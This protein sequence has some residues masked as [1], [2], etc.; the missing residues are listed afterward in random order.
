MVNR[1]YAPIDQDVTLGKI[2]QNMEI[3]VEKKQWY[4]LWGL[5]PISDDKTA[6]IID[7]YGFDEV[8]V[9]SKIK[10]VDW[11]IGIFTG[12]VSIV[13]ATVIVEGTNTDGQ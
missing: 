6:E 3:T 10:F 13:P 8:K 5:V 12:I 4:A 2:G 9:E 7:D 1:V 11:V